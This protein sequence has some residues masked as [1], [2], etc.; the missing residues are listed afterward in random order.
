MRVLG[1]FLLVLFATKYGGKK[2]L[3]RC[4]APAA[5]LLRSKALGLRAHK[6]CVAIRCHLLATVAVQHALNIG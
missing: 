3:T 5:I 4:L 1:I 2:I 6:E